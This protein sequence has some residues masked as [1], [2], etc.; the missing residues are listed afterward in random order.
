MHLKKSC[1]K[2]EAAIN[3]F[4]VFHQVNCSYRKIKTTSIEKRL[5]NKKTVI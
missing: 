4:K 1:L 5:I 3:K 2:F